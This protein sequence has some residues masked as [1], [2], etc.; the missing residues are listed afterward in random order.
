MKAKRVEMQLR[1]PRQGRPVRIV[2]D[3][4]ITTRGVHGGRLLP[5]VLLDASERPEIA[6]LIRVHRTL[7]PGDHT[8]QWGQ[9]EGHEGTVALFLNF[10]RPMELFMALEFEVVRQGILVE[11]TLIGQGI[12]LAC[13]DGE[14]DRWV[15]NP[16]RPSIIVEVGD[17]GFRNEWDELFRKALVRDF[18]SKGLS[19]SDARRAARSAIDELRKFAGLRMRDVPA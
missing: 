16:E 7:G 18:R 13:A 14:D 3:A 9:I 8:V 1:D 17:T 2:A 6:E 10:I 4:A 15:R 11:Q 12:Y 19:R 5:L